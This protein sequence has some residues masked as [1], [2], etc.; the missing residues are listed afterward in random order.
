MQLVDEVQVS[1]SEEEIEDEEDEAENGG[2]SSGSELEQ[3][4]EDDVWLFS[5]VDLYNSDEAGVKLDHSFCSNVPFFLCLGVVYLRMS[6]LF[7]L[8]A[9]GNRTKTSMQSA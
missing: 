7:P 1:G 4:E 5:L 8:S 3:V 6:G 2:E 9:L